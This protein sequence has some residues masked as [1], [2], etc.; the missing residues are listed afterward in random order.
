MTRAR[1]NLVTA[2]VFFVALTSISI[3]VVSRLPGEEGFATSAPLAGA[4]R[5]LRAACPV[6]HAFPPLR[7]EVKETPDS[8]AGCMDPRERDL[9]LKRVSGGMNALSA[10]ACPAPARPCAGTP[11]GVA[12]ITIPTGYAAAIV[13]AQM[14]EQDVVPGETISVHVSAMFGPSTKGEMTGYSVQGCF[15]SDVLVLQNVV[16]SEAFQ[17]QFEYM[18]D[19]EACIVSFSDSMQGDVTAYMTSKRKKAR[20][21]PPDKKYKNVPICT[22]EF[23]VREGLVP[24]VYPHAFGMVDIIENNN[25]IGVS[26]VGLDQDS[27]PVGNNIVLQSMETG[28]VSDYRGEYH[29][30]GHIRVVEKSV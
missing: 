1:A 14:P 4:V 26:M 13:E 8:D 30:T 29:A 17:V 23:K 18:A 15:R 16:N 20:N 9:T 28:F 2:A 21:I 3:G 19:S 5:P 11:P 10:M 27:N 25:A 24:G 12:P 6:P 22:F 7:R